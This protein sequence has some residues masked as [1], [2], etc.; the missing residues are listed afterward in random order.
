MKPTPNELISGVRKLLKEEVGP[1]LEGST[2]ITALKKIMSVLRDIDWNE[3]GFRLIAE[4]DQ[5]LQLLD[6]I[7]AQIVVLED[8]P[9]LSSLQGRIRSCSG[10]SATSFASALQLN[11][12]RRALIAEF[13]EII[14]NEEASPLPS[15]ECATWRSE[16]AKALASMHASSSSDD[17]NPHPV[18]APQQRI[19]S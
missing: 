16:L 19:M 1:E 8:T 12:E 4:N 13:V 14:S 6:R 7:S 10:S 17:T 11:E 5:L 18:K 9:V 3:A 2:G 15:S